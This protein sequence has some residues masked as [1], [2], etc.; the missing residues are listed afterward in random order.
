MLKGEKTEIDENHIIL[1]CQRG[2]KRAFGEIVNKYMK[3][4]YFSAL[5]LTGSHEAALDMSQ[6]AF[7]RAWR[8]IKKFEPGRNFFTWYYQ[9]LRNLCFNFI[10]DRSRHARPFSQ[11]DGDVL[12]SVSDDT[13]D[14]SSAIEHEEIRKSV[15]DALNSLKPHE[16]EIITLKDFQDL[17][18]KEIADILECPIGTVMSRLFTARQALKMK[19][20]DF[21]E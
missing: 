5:G 8:S 19:L 17:S 18:Y 15:W 21:I 9:I 6:D 12:L 3:R 10:R 1:R 2:D 13:Q 7:V 11:I 14:S 4:A 16:R 20:E